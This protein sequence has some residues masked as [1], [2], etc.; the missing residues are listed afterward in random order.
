MTTGLDICQ[1]SEGYALRLPDGSCTSYW[2][3]MG[4]VWTCGFG[5]TGPNVTRHTHWTRQEA[6]QWLQARWLIAE[7]GVRRASPVLSLPENRN[8]LEAITD[9]AYNLGVGRY[10][11]SS[12]RRYVDQKNWT[13]ASA[14][15]PKWNLAGGKVRPGLVTRR[16]SE[17]VL[18]DTPVQNLNVVP[19][20]PIGHQDRANPEVQTQNTGV[21]DASATIPPSSGTRQPDWSRILRDLFLRH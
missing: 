4:C 15:F 7:A 6:V 16:A 1:Q 9:F 19:V 17:R 10:Q 5:T 8:R 2:D 11:A 14:E 13:A 3:S 20:A 18:F 21:P 12:L